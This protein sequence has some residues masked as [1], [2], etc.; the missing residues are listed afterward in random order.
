MFGIWL[1]AALL[2]TG[3]VS[4]AAA[5]CAA[6][7][8]GQ[9]SCGCAPSSCGSAVGRSCCCQGSD[10]RPVLP[11]PP[12]VTPAPPSHGVVAVVPEPAGDLADAAGEPVAS[13]AAPPRVAAPARFL[14]SCAFLC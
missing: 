2:L 7:G 12:A 5:S 4:P 11:A 10:P 1:A 14:L 6:G 9:P 3:A 13:P 8:A